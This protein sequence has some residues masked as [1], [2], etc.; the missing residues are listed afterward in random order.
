MHQTCNAS[1]PRKGLMAAQKIRCLCVFSGSGT[2]RNF[3]HT[4]MNNHVFIYNK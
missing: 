4:H 3:L 2:H 1:G